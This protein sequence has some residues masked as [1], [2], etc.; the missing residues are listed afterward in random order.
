MT[1]VLCVTSRNDKYAF[2]QNHVNVTELF[3]QCTIKN[4]D[5]DLE[6]GTDD[7]RMW[8]HKI[9]VFI[10]PDSFLFLRSFT[11]EKSDFQLSDQNQKFKVFEIVIL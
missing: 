3:Y 11:F 7:S 5:L 10:I 4:I 1:H 8:L 9:L 6:I 2:Q